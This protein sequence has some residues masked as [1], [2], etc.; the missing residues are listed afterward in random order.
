MSFGEDVRKLYGYDLYYGM[1]GW[2]WSDLLDLKFF[3]AFIVL[4]GWW[5]KLLSY[6]SVWIF[7]K[8]YFIG[9]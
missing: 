4:M 9:N 1:S 2:N 6:S 7:L 3:W 5:K 8:M